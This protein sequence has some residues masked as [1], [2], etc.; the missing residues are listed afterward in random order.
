MEFEPS[1]EYWLFIVYIY[2]YRNLE[3]EHD[4]ATTNKMLIFETSLFYGA[5]EA[6]TVNYHQF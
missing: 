5:V 2:T 1:T 6:D 4:A 3:A